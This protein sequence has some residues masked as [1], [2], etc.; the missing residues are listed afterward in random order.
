MK[1]MFLKKLILSGNGKENATIEFQK[2]LNIITGDSDTGK[3]YAFQCLNYILGADKLPKEI[4]EAKG[5]T[6]ISL[7]FSVDEKDFWLER[8]LGDSRVVIRYD[9]KE[10]IIPCKHDPVS[11]NN[12]SRFILSIL[13][14]NDDIIQLKKKADNS[15]R[16]LSFRDLIHL[17]MVDETGI[18]A[19]K[20]AFQSEQHFEKIVRSSIFKYVVSGKDDSEVVQQT[21]TADERLKRAGVVQFL[22]RKKVALIKKIEEIEGNA[23]YKLYSSSQSL[24]DMV[25]RI[26]ELRKSIFNLNATCVEKEKTLE[27]LKKDC[28]SDEIKILDFQKIDAHYM[29]MLNDNGMVQTYAEFLLQVPNLDCP[30]CGKSF[31]ND[32]VFADET[33]DELFEYF[34][35]QS[36]EL[37]QKLSGV[38]ET[39]ADVSARLENNKNKI[40]VIQREL[41]E[42]RQT[43]DELQEELRAL[44]KNIIIIRQLDAMSKALEIYHQELITIEGE[45]VAYSEKV[46]SEKKQQETINSSVFDSYCVLVHKVL[47]QWGFGDELKVEFNSKTLDIIMDSKE[48]TSWGKGYRAFVMSAMV[49]ALMRYCYNNSKVHPGFVI[50][51][52]PLVS[53]KERKIDESGD[54]ISDYMERK[55]IEDILIE[56]CF[57]QVII[58]E[59]KDLKYGYDFNYIEF[60]HDGGR[61]A[62]FIPK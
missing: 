25:S 13:L 4:Q 8:A 56:D 29:K 49:V 31:G 20:S 22:E 38:K 52:S 39:I 46:K 32:F 51:D 41:D 7:L 23:N 44:N 60:N 30:V 45:I 43:L 37:S 54:W 26:N 5:Y 53:L 1:R 14:E 34:R 21:N 10:D 19:E 27:S 61:R 17:C 62:G 2:G 55:M 42:S 24:A 11:N 12:L 33:A 16:T 35:N 50:L 57:H 6:K 28:F 18:I 15:K 36:S 48:R 3:T 47:K 40:K 58:F 59:N 9:D